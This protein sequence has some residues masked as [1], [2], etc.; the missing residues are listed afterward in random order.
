MEYKSGT[1]EMVHITGTD[2][3]IQ[4]CIDG[5]VQWHDVND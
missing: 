2:A 3:G 1:R 4:E 5:L